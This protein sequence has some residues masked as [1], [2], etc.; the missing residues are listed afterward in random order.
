MRE[1]EKEMGGKEE[2]LRGELGGSGGVGGRSGRGSRD[3]GRGIGGLAE[4][5]KSAMEEI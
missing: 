5:L 2:N 4:R 1:K 3:G